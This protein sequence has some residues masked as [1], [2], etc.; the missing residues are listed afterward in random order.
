M[1]SLKSVRVLDAVVE[2][3]IWDCPFDVKLCPPLAVGSADQVPKFIVKFLWPTVEEGEAREGPVK[4]WLVA[5]VVTV[6]LELI[7]EPA[8]VPVAANVATVVS[9]EFPTNP[10][11]CWDWISFK[12]FLKSWRLLFK[13]PK[14]EIVSC[15]FSS[16]LLRFSSWGAVSASTSAFISSVVLIPEPTPIF[17]K[18]SVLLILASYYITT[19]AKLHLSLK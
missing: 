13:I 5:N 9:D 1:A 7:S 19:R 2:T 11:S 17:D 10:Y 14:V 3:E 8:L 15:V 6:R 16:S 4:V 12:I 18:I